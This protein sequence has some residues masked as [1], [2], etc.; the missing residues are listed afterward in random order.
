[1]NNHIVLIGLAALILVLLGFIVYV[2]LSGNGKSARNEKKS[3]TTV[4]K[5]DMSDREILM[6]KHVTVTVTRKVTPLNELAESEMGKSLDMD[7]SV[8]DQMITVDIDF[9]EYDSEAIGSDDEERGASDIDDPALLKSIFD[10]L[11]KSNERELERRSLPDDIS[12]P[13]AD[14]SSLQQSLA[15]T[16]KENNGDDIN[17]VSE[18]STDVNISGDGIDGSA[19]SDVSSVDGHDTVADAAGSDVDEVGL[20]DEIKME[21]GFSDGFDEDL[22]GYVS[23]DERPDEP[24]Y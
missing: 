14:F 8:N 16:N 11:A 12:L 1:M 6:T 13:P 2:L 23:S 18:S 15:D 9:D 4:K 20:E 22:K 5:T 17:E 10:S 21:S 19:S 24:D 3:A 7:D